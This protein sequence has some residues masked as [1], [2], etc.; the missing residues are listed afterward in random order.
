MDLKMEL[1][2]AR[3]SAAEQ[4]DLKRIAAAILAS[5]PDLHDA[6]LPTEELRKMA[7]RL[8]GVDF[9]GN[10][11]SGVGQSNLSN[12]LAIS[13][14]MAAWCARESLRSA[15]FIQGAGAAL[16]Q[17]ARNCAGRPLRVLYAG[18]G[19]FALLVLPLM[20]LWP[21]SFARFTLLDIHR[22]ALDYARTLVSAVGLDDRVEAWVEADAT[23]YRIDPAAPPD[24]IISETMTAALAREPQVA[25]A[26]HLL[27]Q[28]PGALMVPASVRVDCML[29]DHVKE[30][31]NDIAPQRD[32][33]H[34][35]KVFE[36]NA[37]SI[38]LWSEADGPLPGGS[39]TLPPVLEPRYH[40][41]LMTH[42]DVFNGIVLA[43]YACSLNTPRFLPGKPAFQGGEALE[44]SYRLGADPG[45]DFRVLPC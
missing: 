41:R 44:F 13:P 39:V 27:A 11:D 5:G 16:E 35:G 9:S 42:I 17:A 15:A 36:L 45:I 21:A 1:T 40:L 8:S 4:A 7:E 37:A 43:D 22:E 12:G 32:R 14:M 33:I 30:K 18:C 6:F 34:L 3:D 28:A 25:I 23:A 19:P 38:A 31:P 24:V 2:K 10:A 20:A 26:R 29:C